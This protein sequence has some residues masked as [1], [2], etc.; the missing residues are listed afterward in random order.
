MS[1]RPK[2]RDG[3]DETERE[4]ARRIAQDKGR[5]P[6]DH[7]IS[8]P[9][10]A[11]KIREERNPIQR[12]RFGQAQVFRYLRWDLEGVVIDRHSRFISILK[13]E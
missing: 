13:D 9:R 6:E 2:A 8:F 1:G 5:T 12:G 11:K 4:E 7:F 10:P 3:K